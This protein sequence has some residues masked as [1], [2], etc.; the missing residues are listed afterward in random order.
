MVQ[1]ELQVAF[2]T[3]QESFIGI[4]SPWYLLTCSSVPQPATVKAEEL[5]GIYFYSEMFQKGF[6][7]ASS[8]ETWEARWNLTFH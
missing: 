2:Y 3:S 1:V 6:F 7:H 8:C 5:L 4:F